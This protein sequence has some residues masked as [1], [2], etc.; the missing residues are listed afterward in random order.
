MAL[1]VD[2]GTVGV[3]GTRKEV[4]QKLS[5]A[6][7]ILA[8]GVAAVGLELSCSKSVVMATS[9]A[10]AR[11]IARSAKVLGKRVLKVV[12]QTKMLG[13]GNA[14]GNKRDTKVMQQRLKQHTK[15][16]KRI[17]ALRAAGVNTTV[18]QT[19]AGN[20]SMMYGADTSGVSDSLLERQRCSAAAASSA[21]GAGK[22]K[23]V[24]L[25]QADA[26]GGG[27]DPC[28]PAHEM[29]ITALAKAAWE[30]WWTE[31]Q[32][33]GQREHSACQRGLEW[34]L[35]LAVEKVRRCAGSPW[36]I[37]TGPF[38]AVAATTAR[39]K[40]EYLGRL[41]FRTDVGEVLNLAADSPQAVKLR[42]RRS[43]AR[44]R[45]RRI[46]QQIPSLGLG[47]LPP[48]FAGIKAST[49][50]LARKDPLADRWV[51]G[52]T[53]ALTSAVANGQWPQTR[54]KSAHFTED[55]RCQLCLSSAGTLCHRRSCPITAKAR[56]DLYLPKHLVPVYNAL[57][58]DQRKLLLNRALLAPVDLSAYPPRR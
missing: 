7:Q 15:K 30:R 24:L 34:N 49:K 14:A 6:A 17:R 10:V 18:W 21:P 38:T 43:T 39:L 40:W 47:G 46:D 54:L 3:D 42:V 52:C 26:K 27:A 48:V 51:N 37:L 25:W 35:W 19:V 11:A 4:Y 45:A 32:Q 29:P 12:R 28:F 56:G 53:A 36:A 58:A 2:D 23:D 16:R 44:W 22:Q 9:Q 8:K 55:S 33:G 1:Y 57:T 13:N 41:C 5:R 20:P 31:D 50:V